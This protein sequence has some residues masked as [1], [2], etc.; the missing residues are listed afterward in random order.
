MHA[1]FKEGLKA[2]EKAMQKH[3]HADEFP[4]VEEAFHFSKKAHEGQK[5]AS[6]EPYFVHPLATATMIAGH[7]LDGTIISA[8]LLHDTLEDTKTSKEELAEIFGREIACIVE[9]LTKLDLLAFKSRKEQTTAN[10]IR[11][12][13]ASSKDLRVLIIK[14]FDKLHNL[15][16]LKH[17]DRQ[18][19]KRIAA[20]A[21]LVY[22]PISHRLG[23]HSMKYEMEDLCFSTLEPAHYRKLRAEVTTLREKKRKEIR[24]AISC[25]EEK[26]HEIKWRFTEQIKSIYAIHSK[27]INRNLEPGNVNDALILGIIVRSEKECYDAL[28]KLHS[29]FRPLPGKFKDYIAMPENSIYRALHTQVLGPS[30]KP[31]KVYIYSE[32]MNDIGDNGVL[33]LMRCKD[34]SQQLKRF[35]KMFSRMGKPDAKDSKEIAGTLNLDFHNRTMI[36]FT[37]K[38]EA[39]ELPPDSTAIDFAYFK[40]G[41]KAEKA[42]K[43]EINGRLLPLWTR[44]N[45][46]D[47]I[48]LIYAKSP[49]VQISWLSLASSEKVR[50]NI[51]KSLHSYLKPKDGAGFVKF[52]IDSVDKHGQLM[53]QCRIMYRN[54]FNLE[55]CISKVNSD[56]TTGYTEFLVKNTRNSNIDNAVKHLRKLKETIGLHVDYLK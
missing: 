50:R 56:R 33:A 17:L 34:S 10:I 55:T 41:K 37:E 18:R 51:E 23:I 38:G 53:E 13:M 3:G 54:G 25:L 46:G 42:S 36:A 4:L 19:Q 35:E 6:G 32:R 15:R 20:D 45:S 26:N 24:K 22:A 16:T 7:G 31:L 30:K 21:L 2:I 8:A 49:Q 1:D 52:R 11:T 9:S 27:I 43:A 40:D 28:W 29:V 47:R 48:K 14:L 5:R 44:L 39:I 12:I